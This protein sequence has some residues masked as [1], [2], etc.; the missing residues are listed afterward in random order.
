MQYAQISYYLIVLSCPG[1]KYLFWAVNCVR[2]TL[3]Y[4]VPGVFLKRPGLLRIFDI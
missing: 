2:N 1:P 4:L 3:I